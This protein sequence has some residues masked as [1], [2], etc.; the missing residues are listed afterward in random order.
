MVWAL[1]IIVRCT[2]FCPRPRPSALT[3]YNKPDINPV[4][5]KRYSFSGFPWLCLPQSCCDSV[6]VH[7]VCVWPPHGGLQWVCVDGVSVPSQCKKSLLDQKKLAVSIL[8]RECSDYGS[9]CPSTIK[10]TSTPPLSATLRFASPL[11]ESN[12]PPTNGLPSSTP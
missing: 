4:Y 9:C 8:N 12:F 7:N 1:R 6:E 3:V 11:F 10:F 2:M 5:I